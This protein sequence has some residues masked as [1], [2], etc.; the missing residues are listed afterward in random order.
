MRTSIVCL[1]AAIGGPQ[2]RLLAFGIPFFAAA[3]A[4]GQAATPSV[5]PKADP[6]TAVAVLIVR[7]DPQSF[8]GNFADSSQAITALLTSRSVARKVADSMKV[9]N[10]GPN[11]FEQFMQ[12]LPNNLRV[13]TLS[14]SD[15]VTM[16]RLSLRMDDPAK[17]ADVVNRVTDAFKEVAAEYFT[18]TADRAVR[19]LVDR[20]QDIER[21]MED[22][23][24][25]LATLQQE[26][27]GLLV[28]DPGTVRVRYQQ[29]LADIEQYRRR[30]AAAGLLI[31][32]L[33]PVKKAPGVDLEIAH[34]Q[35]EQQTAANELGNLERRR[36]A[37]IEYAKTF[38]QDLLRR[39]QL[40][41]QLE[42]LTGIRDE[43]ERTVERTRTDFELRTADVEVIQTA[44]TPIGA[45][46]AK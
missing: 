28:D 30:Q 16:V 15:R 13:E 42:T 2:T 36:A 23:K 8:G 41:K 18:R 27:T 5:A 7:H 29:I 3:L 33:E 20:T 12:Y 6:N 43:L 34:A 17:A 37:E 39:D 31:E 21:K 40:V 24:R 10:D 14:H 35:A 46:A 25:V 38:T 44:S 32:K 45:P 19:A 1:T 22:Y 26:R 4:F 11:A 9:N